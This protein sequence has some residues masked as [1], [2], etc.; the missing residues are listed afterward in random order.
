MQVVP[1]GVYWK[2]Y[3]HK[4]DRCKYC[5]GLTHPSDD[6]DWAPITLT[7]SATDPPETAQWSKNLLH[8]E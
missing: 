6:C 3:V 5:F 2:G 4:S 8:I 7:P 1:P